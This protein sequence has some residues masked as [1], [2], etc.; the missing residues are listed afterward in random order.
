MTPLQIHDELRP[1]IRGRVIIDDLER[2][3]YS[4]DA[5]PF[6]ILPVAVIVPVDDDDLQTVVKFA[7]ERAM[8]IVPAQA[9]PVSHSPTESFSIS[10]FISEKSWNSAMTGSVCSPA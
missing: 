9:L 5:S 8:P 2:R 7:Y 10:V 6:Q 1:R 3:L 4:T